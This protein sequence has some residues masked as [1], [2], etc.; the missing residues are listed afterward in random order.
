MSKQQQTDAVIEFAEQ[1][2]QNAT[3]SV[4]H[5]E[6][7]LGEARRNVVSPSDGHVRRGFAAEAGARLVELEELKRHTEECRAAL[8][9]ARADLPRRQRERQAAKRL[10]A[11]AER[12]E[13]EAAELRTKVEQ[14]EAD[15]AAKRKTADG[16]LRRAAVTADALAAQEAEEATRA[17][18]AARDRRIGERLAEFS[19]RRAGAPPR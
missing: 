16:H 18:V 7:K 14:L 4:S 1:R 3:A 10:D 6:K 11:E 17:E 5:A 8:E 9:H 2:L 13:S 15:A 12:L 19:R